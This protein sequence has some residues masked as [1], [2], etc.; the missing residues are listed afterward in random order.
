MHCFPLVHLAR[1]FLE[2]LALNARQ[3]NMAVSSFLHGSSFSVFVFFS[4]A[5][6]KSFPLPSSPSF[7]L[8][9]FNCSVPMT[10]R[11]SFLKTLINSRQ[12][13]ELMGNDWRLGKRWKEAPGGFAQHRGTVQGNIITTTHA[14]KFKKKLRVVKKKCLSLYFDLKKE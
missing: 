14:K 11:D 13:N 1:Y 12:E 6:T 10:R 4:F 3:K 8:L 5:P 2:F 9:A 7:F